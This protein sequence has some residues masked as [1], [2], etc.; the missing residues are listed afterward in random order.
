MKLARIISDLGAPWILNVVLFLAL[1][2]GLGAPA[3]G[4]SAALL[5]GVV[6]RAIIAV[7][8]RRGEVSHHHVTKREQR[9]PVFAAILV[10][11]AVAVALLAAL[12]TPREMWI[13]LGAAIG[14]IVVFACVT[15]MLRLKIS[16]HVGLWVTV[17]G[18]LAVVLSPWWALGLVFAPV[19]AWSRLKQDHHTPRELAGGCVAGLVVLACALGVLV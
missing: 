12:P 11:L 2:L 9:K 6:P 7:L 8:M 10:C 5:T 4:V 15:L 3:A 18:Y 1:G 17:W 13:A 14:F 19:V 16:V